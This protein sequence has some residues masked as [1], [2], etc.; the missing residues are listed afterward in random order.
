MSNEINDNRYVFTIVKSGV[1]DFKRFVDDSFVS[2]LF[3]DDEGNVY[4]KRSD[5]IDDQVDF[6]KPDTRLQRDFA[7][8]NMKIVNDTSDIPHVSVNGSNLYTFLEDEMN[9]Q[10]YSYFDAGIW[11]AIG[12]DSCFPDVFPSY[13]VLVSIGTDIFFVCQIESSVVVYE[14]GI[15]SLEKRGEMTNVKLLEAFN[16]NSDILIIVLKEGVD[17]PSQ[18][19]YEDFL[20]AKYEYFKGSPSAFLCEQSG[21]YFT[22][23]AFCQSRSIFP[24]ICK[25]DL[26]LHSFF[27]KNNRLYCVSLLYYPLVQQFVPSMAFGDDNDAWRFFSNI[28]PFGNIYD[29]SKLDICVGPEPEQIVY[30]SCKSQDEIYL[31]YYNR[32]SNTWDYYDREQYLTFDDAKSSSS[33]S[34]LSS[35]SSSFSSSSS[36]FSSSSSQAGMRF[37][38]TQTTDG[39]PALYLGWYSPLFVYNG[40][41]VYKSD[42]GDYYIWWNSNDVSPFFTWVLSNV[43]FNTDPSDPPPG[44]SGWSLTP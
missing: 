16:C 29:V 34:S 10:Y 39:F 28:K 32:Y 38:I 4:F 44:N 14:L 40:K 41:A 27:L 19:I 43:E 36:S 8:K 15:T 23:S 7:G 11:K 13:C 18:I 20:S 1:S 24:C 35:S 31:T 30:C 37:E 3:R 25:E 17:Y 12:G 6:I 22:F 26:N 5:G 42:I 21:G 33:C 2:Y 9:S